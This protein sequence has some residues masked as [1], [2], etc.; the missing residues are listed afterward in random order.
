MVYIFVE[1]CCTMVYA[2]VSCWIGEF[3]GVLAIEAPSYIQHMIHI[4]DMPAR[5]EL[6]S[7]ED[8]SDE[9]IRASRKSMEHNMPDFDSG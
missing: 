4:E 3:K 5:W 8:E 1:L 7:D 9:Y 6:T 2:A